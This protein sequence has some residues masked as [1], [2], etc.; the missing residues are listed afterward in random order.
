MA[1]VQSEAHIPV[2]R[3]P[4]AGNHPP[5]FFVAVLFGADQIPR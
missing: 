1:R 2:L 3:R 5:G 4:A